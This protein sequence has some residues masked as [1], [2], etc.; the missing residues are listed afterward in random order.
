MLDAVR[1]RIVRLA[2][3]VHGAIVSLDRSS[4]TRGAAS[5]G[6]LTFATQVNKLYGDGFLTTADVIDGLHP[7]LPADGVSLGGPR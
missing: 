2:I 4:C 1:R 3:Q 6:S 7:E 5:S